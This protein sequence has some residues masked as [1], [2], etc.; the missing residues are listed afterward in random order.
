MKTL[1]DE[2]HISGI[3]INP[4]YSDVFLKTLNVPHRI[5]CPVDSRGL[6]I[7]VPHGDLLKGEEFWKV[8]GRNKLRSLQMSTPVTMSSNCK[9]EV[10][11]KHVQ[12]SMRDVEDLSHRNSKEDRPEN[13]PMWWLVIQGGEM[14][15]NGCC[16]HIN[17]NAVDW[18]RAARNQAS[19]GQGKMGGRDNLLPGV[20]NLNR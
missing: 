4:I 12:Q 18:V 8:W 17:N 16:G 6:V 19:T 5:K 2:I 9:A 14:K 7:P 20:L 15:E 1:K 13:Q 11:E 3:F 10:T